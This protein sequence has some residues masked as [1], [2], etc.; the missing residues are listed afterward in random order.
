MSE[1]VPHLERHGL[2]ITDIEILRQHYAR[3]LR[4][5]RDRF[6]A[7]RSK[8]MALYDERFCRMWE[9]YLAGSEAS[10]RHIG[11]N[12]FQIQFTK[13]QYALPITRNYMLAEESRLRKLERQR[14]I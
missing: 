8:A 4:I 5:W 9:F 7:N 6:Q 2:Y 1:V 3:T 10:F 14:K 13:D 12:N 11:L